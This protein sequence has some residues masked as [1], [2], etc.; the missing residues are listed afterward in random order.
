MSEQLSVVNL[1]KQFQACGDVKQEYFQVEQEHIQIF[2]CEGMLDEKLLFQTILPELRQQLKDSLKKESNQLS[3]QQTNQAAGQANTENAKQEQVESNT[4]DKKEQQT[5]G[6]P[7]SSQ[8]DGNEKVPE[9]NE[10]TEASKSPQ[11]LNQEQKAS[12]TSSHHQLNN[13]LSQQKGE[14][15]NNNKEQTVSEQQSNHPSNGKA[16]PSET[17]QQL[18]IASG[19]NSTSQQKA[20]EDASLNKNEPI[21]NLTENQTQNQN[22]VQKPNEFSKQTQDNTENQK[23]NQNQ[24]SS[25]GQTIRIEDFMLP[26][27]K[28]VTSLDDAVEQVFRGNCVVVFKESQLYWVVQTAEQPNR[29]PEETSLEVSVKGPRDNFV[30]STTTNIAL[31][32]KRLPTKA[33]AVEKT[34]VGERSKT[35]VAILYFQ[36]IADKKILQEIKQELQS[37]KTDV[38][39]S[40]ELLMEDVSKKM[41]A[42]P[43]YEYTGR[44]DFVV[45]A[46]ARGR[47]AVFVEGS[48]YAMLTPVSFWF[49][50]KS[51]EDNEYPVAYS[52]FQRLL[53]IIG[54]LIGMLLPAFWL[55]LTTF[56]QN[57]LPLQLLATVVQSNTGLPFPSAVEMML[58][59]L[60]FELFRE[61][62]LRMPSIIGGT[63]SVVGGLI[64]GDAA[65]RAGITSPAMVVVIALSTIATFTLVN[66]SVVGLVSLLRISFIGVT[67]IFGLF[68][69]LFSMYMSILLI[70]NIKVFGVPYLNVA[71]DL[72]L[73]TFLKTFIRLNHA[74]YTKRPEALKTQDKTRSVKSKGRK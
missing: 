3:K 51:G 73:K 16:N 59:V 20:S 6:Q 62:G 11:Q 15:Q 42:I 49:L 12:P 21:S 24:S 48:A 53:R 30:E 4:T 19:E 2:Y 43:R 25:I 55:A 64:I 1:V 9:I 13:Q 8:A 69:F 58:M 44:P 63:I 31:V 28:E 27:L 40:G 14:E 35:T 37:I 36:D 61:A 54:L 47:Y 29:Q 7:A 5:E 17:N 33:L 34:V 32:R 52:S 39:F 74:E 23:T 38:I 26:G 10:L 45:Q 71:A 41:L 56:H 65:I 68:G 22:Q 60:F 57:Q 66:Q 67:A 50:V 72:N 46:L 70:A 18:H